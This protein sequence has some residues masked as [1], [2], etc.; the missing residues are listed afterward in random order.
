[1]R[2]REVYNGK[3]FNQESE[4][5]TVLK[6]IVSDFAS[7]AKE[8]GVIPIV[9]I[10]NN[11][12]RGDHLFRLLEPILELNNVPYLST[13]RIVPPENP[14]FFIAR[15]THFIPA[16]DLELANEMGKIIES[17]KVKRNKWE[18]NLS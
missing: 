7:L 12:N 6:K 14:N 3:E 18:K 16:K 5:V 1:M 9:Y 15:D 4:E 2:I 17:E 13:H 11:Q 8:D 10:V